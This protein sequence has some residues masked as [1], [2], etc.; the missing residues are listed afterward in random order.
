MLLNAELLQ[1]INIYENGIGALHLCFLKDKPRKL[2]CFRF[3]SGPHLG[4]TLLPWGMNK[5]MD[6]QK[7]S[8][9]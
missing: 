7:D 3:Y 4:S 5:V 6:F 2:K 9:S 1:K 8:G